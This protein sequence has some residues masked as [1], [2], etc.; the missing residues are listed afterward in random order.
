MFLKI[1]KKIN[2]IGYRRT[3]HLIV[4]KIKNIVFIKLNFTLNDYN[5]THKE[6]IYYWKCY[7]Y[8]EKKYRKVLEK[9]PK[10]NGGGKPAKIIWFCWLQGEEEMPA[11]SKRCLQ[12]IKNNITDREIKIIT[13]KNLNEYIELPEYIVQKYN[14]GIISNTHLSDL[15]RL[16]LLCKYGGTWIDSTAYVTC[17]DENIFDKELFLFKN[18]N[19]FWFENKNNFNNEPIIADN[20]FITA[21]SGNPI[22]ETVKTL[23]YTYWKENNYLIDYFIFHYM[24]TLTV[25]YKYKDEFDKMPDYP[26][27]N[28]HLMQYE[29]LNSI[30][31]EKLNTIKKLSSIHKLTYKVDSSKIKEE[32]LFK[33][34]VRGDINDY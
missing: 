34:I 25:N 9:M 22:L 30:N 23:L 19:S 21:A 33:Y 7:K 29:M 6:M 17:Y 15:I 12:S 3:F 24:F 28:P 5:E 16:E 4:E 8:V 13:L 1:K 11:L 20:W 26:H 18:C 32:S 14:K 2:C 27:I 10:E 31:E